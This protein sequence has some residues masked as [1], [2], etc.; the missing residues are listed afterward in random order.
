MVKGNKKIIN[1]NKFKTGDLVFAK[2]KG[3]SHWP[4]RVSCCYLIN[5]KKNLILNQQIFV[6]LFFF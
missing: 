6:C 5:L 1:N 2:V 3:F 4:A